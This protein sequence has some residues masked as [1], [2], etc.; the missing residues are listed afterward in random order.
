MSVS[1]QARKHV[2][3]G[4]LL[5]VVA[6]MV[7]LAFASVPLYRMLCQ[8]IGLGG[9][10]QVAT[11]G[12]D[13]VANEIVTVHFD[14][15]IDK[16]LPWEFRPKQKSVDVKVGETINVAYYAKNLS[17]QP[18]RGTATFNVTPDKIGIYFNKIQCFCFEEQTLA[19]HQEVDMSVQFFVDP[20]MLKDKTTEEVRTITL[21]YT[22]FRSLNDLPA[23]THKT[24]AAQV[25]PVTQKTN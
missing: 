10:T 21:S 1:L 14:A 13:T 11:S 18:V 8:A 12:P 7:G 2:T 20:A 19:P 5:V 4:A 22:F 25:V 17:D 16:E 3:A 15:N 9:T 6:G 23:A 24:A